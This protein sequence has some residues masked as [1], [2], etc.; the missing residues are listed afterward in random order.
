MVEGRT[1]AHQRSTMLA[2]HHE[3]ARTA[4]DGVLIENQ[5]APS[6][7]S[8]SLAS[9]IVMRTKSFV[10]LRPRKA[11]S[12]AYRSGHVQV[13]RSRS[14]FQ[15]SQ[16]RTEFPTDEYF[17]EGVKAV[18]SRSFQRLADQARQSKVSRVAAHWSS[19][20]PQTEFQVF[21]ACPGP[22]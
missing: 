19:R 2:P 1:A 3:V 7:C 15:E 18:L 22:S 12:P 10:A 16:L 9:T 11:V 20:D 5:M 17:S 21:R 6:S 14:A 4:V 13:R 8:R